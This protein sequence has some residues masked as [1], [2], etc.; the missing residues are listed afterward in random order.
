MYRDDGC[1]A[2][3]FGGKTMLFL[4]LNSVCKIYTVFLL[5]SNRVGSSLLSGMVQC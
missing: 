1:G 3:G 4:G 2:D 5:L